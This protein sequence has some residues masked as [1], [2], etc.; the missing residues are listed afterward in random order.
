MD[1]TPALTLR[2]TPTARS[3]IA[4]I[5]DYVG[6]Q[7]PQA[8]NAIEAGLHGVFDLLQNFPL[9]GTATTHK[10]L[11][12]CVVAPFPY[13]VFYRVKPSTLFSVAVRHTARRPR[14]R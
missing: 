12:R 4:R 14:F 6:N 10:D 1:E 7:S 5:L 13:V 11:R 9:A 8:R 2:F 3:D